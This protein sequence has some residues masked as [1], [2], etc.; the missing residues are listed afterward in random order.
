MAADAVFY[1]I[2]LERDPSVSYEDVAEKMNLAIDWFR[3]NPRV[4]IVYSTSDSEKWYQRLRKLA[5]ES[6]SLFICKLDISDRQGWIT[7][8]F[9]DWI[10]KQEKRRSAA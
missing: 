3:I 4:W 8:G 2:Y 1:M 9:W 7:S 5:G 10:R 6:G